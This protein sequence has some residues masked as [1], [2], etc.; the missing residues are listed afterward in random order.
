MRSVC[1]KLWPPSWLTT[2]CWILL[3]CVHHPSLSSLA[4]SSLQSK[5][6]IHN[7]F[8]RLNPQLDKVIIWGGLSEVFRSITVYLWSHD[9][10]TVLATGV[11]SAQ[12]GCSI[13]LKGRCRH[14]EKK[15]WINFGV[16]VKE[17]KTGI[18]AITEF[19]RIPPLPLYY[20]GTSEARYRHI[21]KHTLVS[22]TWLVQ[23][24]W[25]H[26]GA[27]PAKI[28]PKGGPTLI[29]GMHCHSLVSKKHVINIWW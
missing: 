28:M 29:F 20:L 22:W 11:W 1:A 10:T 17:V 18:K 25:P 5:R 19:S 2:F 12:T 15:L 7:V 27:Q 26:K 6:P 8:L 3:N 13:L 23:T 14:S 21:H 9:I 4:S 24:H 16:T